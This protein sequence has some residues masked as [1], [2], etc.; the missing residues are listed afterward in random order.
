ML[1]EYRKIVQERCA[2]RN[3]FKSM[4]LS[5]GRKQNDRNQY[6]GTFA[7]RCTPCARDKSIELVRY[8]FGTLRHLRT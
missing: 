7:T 8:H 3:A 4:S 5:T 1:S 2:L 6:F